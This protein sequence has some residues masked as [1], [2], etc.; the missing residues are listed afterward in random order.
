[1]YNAHRA[2]YRRGAYMR[3]V[4]WIVSSLPG[5]G[6]VHTPVGF[7]EDKK[8][9]I[10]DNELDP[11]ELPSNLRHTAQSIRW[12]HLNLEV[13]YET[14]YYSNVV[15]AALSDSDKQQEYADKWGAFCTGT[16]KAPRFED[17]V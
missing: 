8:F 10:N 9:V 17:L 5:Y 13:Q 15:V 7:T 2:F 12:T 14:D 6:A 11:E 1:M 3:L 16:G 4:G